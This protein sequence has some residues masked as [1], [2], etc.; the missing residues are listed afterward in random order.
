MAQF[1]FRLDTVLK[2]RRQQRDQA[3]AELA[4][5]H[6]AAAILARQKEQLAAA[7]REIQ[8]R[9]RN[10]TEGSINVDRLLEAHRFHLLLGAKRQEL[11]AQE[12]T[13]NEEVERRQAAVVEADRQVKLLEKLR[14]KQARRH[15]QAESRRE[16]A[17]ID[18]IAQLRRAGKR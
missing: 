11:S 10:D 7:M 6:H 8:M 17:A 9:R 18:E 16:Q 4:D 15:A 5:A 1:R 13:L 14:E 12:Q 3:R 2:V